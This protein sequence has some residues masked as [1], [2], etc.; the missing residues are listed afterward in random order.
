MNDIDWNCIKHEDINLYA[1][2][3][4][5]KIIELAKGCIPNATVRIKPRDVP[6]MNRELKLLIRRR[7]RAY[8]RAKRTDSFLD[9]SKFRKLRNSVVSKIRIS[10]FAYMS[11]LSEKIISGNLTAKDWWRTIKSFTTPA[12][13]S[14]PPLVDPNTGEIVYDDDVKATLLNNYFAS[15]SYIDDT[16]HDMPNVQCS[17]ESLNHLL[18]TPTEV[19]DALKCLKTAKASGP[20][21]LSNRI[22]RELTVQL[23]SPLCDLFNFSLGCGKVPN[24]WKIANVCAIFKKG[25]SSAP[26]NYRP[27]SLLNSLEKVFE[28]V[29]FKHVFNFLHD[30]NFFTKSQSGFMPGDSTV[31]QLCY[32]YN[33]FCKALDDG[34]E[35]R[36]VFF[37]ISK[38]FDRV[39][40]QGLLLKLNA[41]GI[42]GNLLVWFSDYL[43]NRQQ[44]VVIPGGSSNLSPILA[45]VPQGSLLGPLLF[46][47]YINDIVCNISSQINLFADDTSLYMIVRD[48]SDTARIMQNDIEKISAWADSWLVKF[49]PLKS[50]TLLISRKINK[51]FHPPLLMLGEPIMNVGC[52]RHLGVV[53]SSD[54]SW[55]EH[56]N[57]IK[58]RAWKRVHMLRSLKYTLNRKSLEILYFSFVRPVLEYADVVWDNCTNQEKLDMER[59][60]YEAAR[61]ITG[62]TKLV[63]IADLL[64]ESGLDTLSERRKKHKLILFYKMVNSISPPYLSSLTP[65]SIGQSTSY[66]L[67]NA[68]NLTTI[69][70]RTS[71]YTSSF[72]PQTVKDWNVLSSEIRNA[73]SIESF[74]KL[75]N[76]ESRKSNKLFYYGKRKQQVIHAQLRTKCSSLA[77]HLYMKSITPS[78]NCRCGAV[79]TTKHFFLSCPLYNTIRQTL[80]DR[81]IDLT[82]NCD[83][84]TIVYGDFN[85]DLTTNRSVFSAVHRYIELSK[86]FE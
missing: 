5:N 58:E 18:I 64:I 23:S 60:Q 83:K 36:V 7:K 3:L 84:E 47:V 37:D 26:S 35:V 72:L 51:N 24:Q 30:N 75:L 38:A 66:R 44:K 55:H 80:L 41:A 15:Q 70:S 17:N 46:L 56:I 53:L 45:G 19:E 62:C 14:I 81:I 2:N 77:H 78:P 82:G 9:W 39:W 12:S 49:N 65:S 33:S 8:K 4:T 25:D 34:L 48:P 10:K 13:T 59:I 20:D 71:L 6:W 11:S 52:H 1:Q 61:I 21:S 50:E 27:I 85:Q 74:K 22:L 67:R 63:T 86:R 76:S 54:G 68:D 40:H 79:E 16:Y 31:N 69:N 32:L 42:R 57:S 73:P 43:S 28:R 29:I